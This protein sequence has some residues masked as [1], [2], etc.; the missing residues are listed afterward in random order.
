[1]KKSQWPDEDNKIE[2]SAWEDGCEKGR[3]EIAPRVSAE[4]IH[5]VRASD[6]PAVIWQN[7]KTTLGSKRWT[8][9]PALRR[10]V[11][12]VEKRSTQPIRA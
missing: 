6:D 9:R 11:F 2:Y 1:M 12:H 5:I 4:V 8:I 3:A 10:Q 7:F